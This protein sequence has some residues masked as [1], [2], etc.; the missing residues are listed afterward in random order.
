MLRPV[1][2]GLLTASAVEPS[3]SGP[4]N[5]VLSCS[6]PQAAYTCGDLGGIA[7]YGPYACGT[8]WY[9]TL[10]MPGRVPLATCALPKGV[11]Y[12]L[13]YLLTGGDA[14][15]RFEARAD[16]HAGMFTLDFVY[17]H[18]HSCMLPRQFGRELSPDAD[19]RV[20]QKLDVLRAGAMVGEVDPDSSVP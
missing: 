2:S 3:A 9:A 5:W 8:I 11:R 18:L 4:L 7:S 10:C 1:L 20:H 19:G 13:T 6:G 12:L 16:S 14:P 15:D 17:S